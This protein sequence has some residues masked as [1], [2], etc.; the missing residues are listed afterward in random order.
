[1]NNGYSLPIEDAQLRWVDNMPDYLPN[2]VS[3]RKDISIG[4]NELLVNFPN[5]ARFHVTNGRNIDIA[6][7]PNGTREAA[8]FFMMATP[9]GAL[10]HQRGELPLHASAV[11]PPS[12]SKALLI[13][14]KSGAGKSTTAAA[15]AQRGWIVIND[16]IS[17]VSSHNN[18]PHVWPGFIKLKLWKQSC[19]LLRLNS[20]SLSRTR[21]MKEKFFWQADT[22][23]ALDNAIPIGA[24][25]EL[26]QED[27]TIQKEFISRQR[28]KEV[29]QLLIRQTFRPRL[30]SPLGC[31]ASHFNQLQV[32]A[33]KLSCYRVDNSRSISIDDLADRLIALCEV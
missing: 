28:G 20:A 11:V 7:H 24:I 5:I 17:R 12:G 30:L 19:E 21:G 25:I 1:M 26:A 18:Q 32:N 31:Q 9:F 8:L 4:P 2:A 3:V 29:M 16:D 23:V 13:A 33:P 10:I 6:M 14:G 27:D 15:L 22:T